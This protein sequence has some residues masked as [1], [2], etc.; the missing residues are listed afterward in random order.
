VHLDDDQRER[1]VEEL[2]KDK[3]RPTQGDC[4]SIFRK[5]EQK[6]QGQALTPV[7]QAAAEQDLRHMWMEA[8]GKPEDIGIVWDDG[9]MDIRVRMPPA[10]GLIDIKIERPLTSVRPEV[11]R[12]YGLGDDT[13]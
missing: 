7:T 8:G 6:W 11:Q 5:M 12:Y 2:T 9:K 3:P 13:C 1:M 4:I 10:P